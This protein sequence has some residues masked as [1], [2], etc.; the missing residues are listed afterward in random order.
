MNALTPIPT[1]AVGITLP[2]DTTKADWLGL[3]RDLYQQRKSLDWLLADAVSAGIA[4]F[5]KQEAFDFLAEQL[6]VE[7]KQ[8]RLATK[9]A[10]AFPAS[11]RADDVPFEVHAYIAELPAERR[12]ETLQRASSEHWGVKRAK[13]VVTE[14]RAQAAMFEDEDEETRRAVEIIRAWNRAP[15]ESRRYF[16]DLAEPANFG[17]IDEDEVE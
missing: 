15:V 14:H 5:G 12:L 10:A 8:L 17:A 3:C 16:W 2:A 1:A 4:L 13:E 7:P 11:Q 6:P 9:V